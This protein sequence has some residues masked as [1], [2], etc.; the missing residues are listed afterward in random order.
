M[1]TNLKKQEYLKRLMDL[2]IP[3]V[4]QTFPKDFHVDV[5]GWS[6]VDYEETRY[7]DVQLTDN[8][9]AELAVA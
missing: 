7:I 6:F 1:I 9:V 3:K 5:N 4:Y 2:G 8:E